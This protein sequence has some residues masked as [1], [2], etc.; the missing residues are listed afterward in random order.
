MQNQQSPQD[1]EIDL[2]DYINI[3]IKRKKLILFL[4]FAAAAISAINVLL[5]PKVYKVTS[6]IQLGSVNELLIQK[7]EASEIILS[8][9]LLS[10]IIKE[11][12]LNIGVDNLRQNIDVENIKSTNLL[13]IGVT[14]PDFETG[15]Q[16]SNA[17]L[18]RVI[19]QGESIYQERVSITKERLNELDAEIKNAQ[20]DIF[21]TQNLM[22]G[23]PSSANISQADASLRIILLQNTLP[24]YENNL[25]MLR[26]QKNDLKI[27]LANAK[28]FKIFD[29]P[30]K[31]KYPIGK[32]VKR[33]VVISGFLGLI[34]GVFLA[35]CMEF[36]Q[37]SKNKKC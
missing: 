2:R 24:S 16:I 35:F 1:D 31:P 18:S 19:S 32:N 7:E 34:S 25:T 26:N 17:I 22:S 9:S 36:W 13:K 23:L 28:E 27:L 10:S 21:R 6:T 3:L 30:V 20:E 4:F 14:N 12:N 8:R 37:K 5:A 29:S 33:K 11:F 15:I